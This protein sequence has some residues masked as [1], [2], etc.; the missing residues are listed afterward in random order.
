MIPTQQ[1]KLKDVVEQL[2]FFVGSQDTLESST[3]AR[4]LQPFDTR[5]VEFL[6]SVAQDILRKPEARQYSD[7][8]TFGFWIREAN[9]HSMKKRL[10][11]TNGCPIRIG[12]GL[13][14][15]IAPSNVPVNYAYSLAVGLLTGNA[16]IVR[17]PSKRF[18]QI[19]IINDSLRSA[20]ERHPSMR[21]YINLVSYGHEKDVNDYLSSLCQ[22]RIIWGG[23]KT[24]A[25]IRRS[26]LSPRASDVTFADRYSIAIVDSD[27]YLRAG[28]KA[29]VAERFYNDTFFSDQ[30]ACTSPRLIV[31]TGKNVDQASELFWSNLDT[32]VRSKYQIEEVQVVNK[33]TSAC[34][35]AAHHKSSITSQSENKIV[36]I[37]IPELTPDIMDYRDNSGYFYEYHCR[38]LEDIFVLCKDERL[39]TISHLGCLEDLRHLMSD[40][41]LKGVD[42]IVPIGKTMDFD[43]FWDG[44]NLYDRL[45]R[46]IALS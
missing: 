41:G 43:F 22:G 19:G 10:A 16:N 17:I 38:D 13:L 32:L 6:G 15:H 42:R 14:F 27:E 23:D 18:P 2:E 9:L 25:E 21:P 20:L 39:Q 33:L 26:P 28:D 7:V 11:D 40:Y 3:S 8:M 45:T 31:W 46:V 12:R 37:A 29:S 24:I 5:I 34:C 4:A 1:A 30:N 36:R 35:F 44:Y